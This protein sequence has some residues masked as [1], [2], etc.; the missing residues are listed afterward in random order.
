[1]NT[2]N[3]SN[4]Q[5]QK[6]KKRTRKPDPKGTLATGRKSQAKTP[7]GLA[8][9]HPRATEAEVEDRVLATMKLVIEGKSTTDIKSHFRR[10]HEIQWCHALRYLRLARERLREETGLTDEFTIQDM[11]VQHY[12]AAM[13]KFRTY[14]EPKDQMVALKHAGAIYGVAAPTKVAPTTPDGDKSYQSAEMTKAALR[15]CTVE[16]LEVLAKVRERIKT[17][18]QQRKSGSN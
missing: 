9:P 17:M 4:G 10:E 13:N 15:L 14:T 8:N 18:T 7:E 6:K 5:P 16:E 12:A 3:G 2:N 1:M 11:R